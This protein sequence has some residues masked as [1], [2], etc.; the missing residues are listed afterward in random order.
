MAGI[1]ADETSRNSFTLSVP[2]EALG[3]TSTT[4]A[5][6]VLYWDGTV[7][8]ARSDAV[9]GTGTTVINQIARWADTTHGTLKSSPILI[10]NNGEFTDAIGNRF[11]YD[12]AAKLNVMLGYGVLSVVAAGGNNTG[13]GENALNLVSSGDNNIGL[14][15][16]AAVNLTTGSSNTILGTNSAATLVG[17]SHNIVIGNGADVSASIT[18]GQIVIGNAD[19]ESAS[20]A[21]IGLGITPDYKITIKIGTHLYT[22]AALRT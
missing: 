18:N 19:V 10:T 2:L 6:D 7:W 22:F 9:F 14:G 4:S 8:D 5:G 1:L 12:N 16:G 13:I 17:G 20:V 15:K 21:A 3:V 11:L